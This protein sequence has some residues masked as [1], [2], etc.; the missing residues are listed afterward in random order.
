MATER[1]WRRVYVRMWRNGSF[2]R[3]TRLPPS[4]QSLW[5]YLTTSP[6]STPLPGVIIDGKAAMAEILEWDLAVF[7]E[8]F[9]ELERER[10]A[11]ADWSSRLIWLPAGPRL[12]P[13]ISPNVVRAWGKTFKKLPECDLKQR[14]Q[15]DLLTYLQGLGP[16]FW[17][18]FAEVFEAFAPRAR[19]VRNSSL[20]TDS[21][22]VEEEVIPP[23]TPSTPDR[24]LREGAEIVA[25]FKRWSAEKLGTL[26]V[27][28]PKRRAAAHARLVEHGSGCLQAII[29]EVLA[30][31][32]LR[33]HNDR[34]WKADVDWVLNPNNAAKVL[35]G[36]YRRWGAG[37]RPL[38]PQER[39]EAQRRAELAV[40]GHDPTA[41]PEWRWGWSR[42]DA[43]KYG[44]P[45]Y[46]TQASPTKHRLWEEYIDRH[47]GT[48]GMEAELRAWPTFDEW[49]HQRE[50]TT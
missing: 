38:T 10:M 26:R 29:D 2:A 12:N 32:G 33:G 50:E 17:E 7:E 41:K 3:L 24:S 5:C 30:S 49:L 28:T 16:S 47:A 6:E 42:D 25:F 8:C 4:G 35:E 48:L 15:Q 46:G 11:V 20:F 18:A 43:E 1:M 23:P 31:P 13:P 21:E 44:G 22:E 39:A 40:G 36:K 34:E 37:K 9:A 14:I 27:I 45:E 19:V